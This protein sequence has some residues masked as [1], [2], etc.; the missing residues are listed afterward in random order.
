MV[1]TKGH[2]SSKAGIMYGM[3]GLSMISIETI[4]AEDSFKVGDQTQWS[5]KL[6]RT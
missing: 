3:T 4:W 1:G 5:G 2:G 6:G